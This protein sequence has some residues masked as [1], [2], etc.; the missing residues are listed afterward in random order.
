MA[1]TTKRLMFDG[2]WGWLFFWAAIGGL[3][4]WLLMP[5]AVFYY[6]RHVR[7]VVTTE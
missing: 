3:T 7:A 5:I 4:G 6:L 2:S 1:T